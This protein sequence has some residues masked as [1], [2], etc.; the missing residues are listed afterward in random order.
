MWLII[1]RLLGDKLSK[2]CCI[3]KPFT[4]NASNVSDTCKQTVIQTA[5]IIANTRTTKRP[6]GNQ[7]KTLLCLFCNINLFEVMAE[8]LTVPKSQSKCHYQSHAF[9][10]K[11]KEIN[12]C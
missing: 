2:K 5:L 9:C 10:Y 11:L 6:C 8:Q 3:F 12:V 1:K 7:D 4:K